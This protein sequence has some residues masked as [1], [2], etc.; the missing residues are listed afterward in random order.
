MNVPYYFENIKSSRIQ[1]FQTVSS[2]QHLL[3]QLTIM[4]S[5]CGRFA[6]TFKL[7]DYCLVG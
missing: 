1:R 2:E 3:I 5:D 7:S 6:M 4:S